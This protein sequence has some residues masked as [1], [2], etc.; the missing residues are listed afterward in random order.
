MAPARNRGQ[1]ARLL[2]RFWWR[3][4]TAFTWPPQREWLAAAAVLVVFIALAVP[5]ASRAGLIVLSWPPALDALGLMPLRVLLLPA[6]LEEVLFRVL[7]NPHPSEFA[8]RVRV[9]T[10]AALSLA[11]YVLLH[12][13]GNLLSAGQAPFTA[14][15]FLLLVALLGSACLLLYRRSGSLWPP[16]MLHWLVVTGWLAFGGRGLLS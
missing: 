7:P 13:L 4:R 5:I 16:L 10:S 3:L 9:W 2:R 8:G 14:P 1:V 11:A 15:A 6:L 12:P